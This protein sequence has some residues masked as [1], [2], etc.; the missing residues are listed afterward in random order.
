MKRLV[1]LS[2]VFLCSV[3]A[4]SQTLSERRAGAKA[5]QNVTITNILPFEI[6]SPPLVVAH[7]S[8]FSAFTLGQPASEGLEILAE[9]GNPAPMAEML[10]EYEAVTATAASDGPLLPGESVTIQVNAKAGDHI[11]VFAMLI[12]TN[13]GFMTATLPARVI[14]NFKAGSA[15]SNKA[16]GH[17]F[18]AGTEPNTESCMDIPGCGGG[19]GP[20][21]DVG[22]VHTHLGIQGVGEI[23]GNYDWRGPVATI[24]TSRN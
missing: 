17:V 14:P 5:V 22:F 23:S 7:S 12:H 1:I 9:G 16:Y 24:Y 8:D 15:G 6:L 21:G 18:D 2:M 10:A 4:F 13:D 19:E 11:S 3:A 20:D